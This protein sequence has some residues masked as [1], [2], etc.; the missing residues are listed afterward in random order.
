MCYSI[1]GDAPL[2]TEDGLGKNQ[3]SNSVC[4]LIVPVHSYRHHW[5]F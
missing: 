2:A 3:W 5:S 4:N 1:V